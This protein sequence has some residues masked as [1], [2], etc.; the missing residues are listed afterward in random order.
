MPAGLLPPEESVMTVAAAAEGPYRQAFSDFTAYRHEL[1][2]LARL[3]R[4]AFNQFEALGL[5]TRQQ[6]AWRITD[7]SAL[8]AIAFRPSVPMPVAANLLPSL[9]IPAHQLLFTNGRFTPSLS[10]FEEI[11]HTAFIGNIS[12][13]LRIHPEQIEHHL[14]QLPGLKQHPFAMLNTAFWEDGVFIHL[15]PDTVIETP[16]HIIFHSVGDEIAVYPRLLLVLEQHAQATIVVEHRGKG[17]YLNAPL[18]ELSVGDGATLHYHEVQ[19]NASQAFHLGALRLRQGRDS[20]THTH[21]FSSGGQLARTDVEALL[22]DEGASCYLNGLTLARRNQLSDYHIRVEHAHPYGSSEQIFRNVL[23]DQAHTVFD[24]M[25]YV[26]PHAQKTDARQLNQN[27]LL[28]RQARANATPQLEILADDVKCS[29]GSTTGFLSPDAKFYLRA[30]GIDS[31]QAHT[32]LV[33]AFANDSLNR[34][35][36]VALRERLSQQ[37]AARLAPDTLEEATAL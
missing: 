8:K 16:I 18:V 22:D 35:K 6:E 23:N 36:L 2:Y 20:Q 29:H 12:H 30:R 15:Q 10:H 24:G 33:H 28:S 17:R 1:D 37:L 21:L 34:I 13:A 14:D 5:P 7:L 26:H 9:D 27:L 31:Q 25:V 3:R 4:E 32:M 19:D 11:P